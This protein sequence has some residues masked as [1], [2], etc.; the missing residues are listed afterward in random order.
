MHTHTH[1]HT[2]TLT[3]TLTHTHTQTPVRLLRVSKPDL[4]AWAASFLG[5]LFLD[6]EYGVPMGLAVNLL[7][8]LFHMARPQHTLV[9]ATRAAAALSL[10]DAGS[11]DVAVPDEIL[12]LRLGS[13]F[14]FPTVEDTVFLITERIRGTGCQRVVLDF[15]KVSQIDYTGVHELA[16]LAKFC[17]EHDSI[18]LCAA[19]LEDDVREVCL[20][21]CAPGCSQPTPPNPSHTRTHSQV[22]ER[23]RL[24]D[25]WNVFPTVHDA[26][27]SRVHEL[28]PSTD[29]ARPASRPHDEHSRL[30]V[31]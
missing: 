24:S 25:V 27:H 16:E 28:T 22:T 8:M 19:N 26:V 5:C 21:L 31:D 10:N 4:L 9:K 20:L 15:T 30:L 12:V 1:T 6:I 7:F 3:H 2:H 23:A 18:A 29:H 13:D 14:L 11:A 17:R